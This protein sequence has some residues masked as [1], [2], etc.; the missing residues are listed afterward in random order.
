MWEWGRRIYN[1]KKSKIL[2]HEVLRKIKQKKPIDE[3]AAAWTGGV[4]G[5]E[6]SAGDS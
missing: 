1:Q 2:I 3:C 6:G 5:D 4:A